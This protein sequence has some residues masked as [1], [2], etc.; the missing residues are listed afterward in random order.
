MQMQLSS[1]PAHY[2]MALTSLP[3][4]LFP[5]GNFQVAGLALLP[6]AQNR[7]L[8]VTSGRQLNFSNA[9]LSLLQ[10]GCFC[11]ADRQKN[12]K[13]G[14]QTNQPNDVHSVQAG[15]DPQDGVNHSASWQQG[16]KLC[17]SQT[18]EQESSP[19]RQ[20]CLPSLPHQ[21]EV[22]SPTPSLTRWLIFALCDR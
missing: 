21:Q 5:V 3:L 20:L 6:A 4:S 17:H 9:W 10:R 19:F 13:R 7:P 16:I 12:A 22:E 18:S 15:T 14:R 1:C 2:K 11:K 8:E